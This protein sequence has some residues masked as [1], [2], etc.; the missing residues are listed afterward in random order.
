M[1]IFI[2][3]FLL[4]ISLTIVQAQNNSTL[5]LYDSLSVKQL[6]TLTFNNLSI[7]EYKILTE[8]ALQLIKDSVDNERKFKGDVLLSLIADNLGTEIDSCNLNPT[9]NNVKD[10]LIIFEENGYFIYQPKIHDFLKLA[11]Y[12]CEGEYYYI[13]KR[14]KSVSFFFPV[15]GIFIV[16][17][18]FSIMNLIGLIKWKP[19]KVYNRITIIITIII[20]MLSIAFKLTCNNYVKENKFYGIAI[21]HNPCD[22]TE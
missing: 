22:C 3:L 17:I 2:S 15:L 9:Q 18:I 5:V 20:I 4:S 8:Y 21:E 14:A 10:L 1:K 6:D 7:D 19:R 11:H 16:G 12:T 13:L